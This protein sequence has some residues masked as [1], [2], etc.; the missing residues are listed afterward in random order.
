MKLV[1]RFSACSLLA[2]TLAHDAWAFKPKTHVASANETLDQLA[3]VITFE[4][5]TDGDTLSFAVDGQILTVNV[6]AREAYWAVLNQPE[7]FRAGS[8]GPDGFLDPISGQL[9]AHGNQSELLADIAGELTGEEPEELATHAPLSSRTSLAQFRSIDY[10][11]AMLRFAA[12]D[13][14]FPG[15]DTEREQVLAFVIGYVSHGIGDGFAHTWINEFANGA[16]DVGAGDGIYGPLTEE[17][18]HVAIERFVDEL[19]PNE[20]VNLPG[21]TQRQRLQFQAPKAFLD[22]FYSAPVSSFPLAPD[23]DASPEDFFNFFARVDLVH[24]G[25]VSTFFNAQER[26]ADSVVGWSRLGPFFDLAE[27]YQ[28]G[29]FANTFLDVVD[30]PDQLKHDLAEL[31]PAVDP[32]DLVTGGVVNCYDPIGGDQGPTE[33]EALRKAWRYLGTMNDRLD[34]YRLK[35]Q[36]ARRNWLHL[37]EC[38]LQNITNVDCFEANVANPPAIRDACTVVA[39]L[40]FEDEGNP[41]GLFRGE[42]SEHGSPDVTEYLSDLRDSFRGGSDNSFEANNDHFHIGQNVL[43]MLEYLTD[44]GMVVDE[45]ADVIVPSGTDDDGVNI[46]ERYEDFCAQVR[47]PAYEN[48]LDLELLE[49]AVAGR[50][51]KC[52]AEHGKCV[53]DEVAECLGDAC[54]SEC[55]DWLVLPCDEICGEGG[56]ST[57][58][59]AC[60]AVF[61]PGPFTPCLGVCSGICG[62]FDDERAGCTELAHDVTNCSLE[63]IVCSYENMERAVRQDNYGKQLLTPFKEACD[64]VDDALAYVEQC[65]SSPANLQACVCAN[66]TTAQCQQLQQIQQNAQQILNVLDTV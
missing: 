64:T 14:A 10:A 54:H 51:L 56:A 57:C 22:A 37:S 11:T 55:D 6:S 19:L 25:P 45:F 62:V 2:L 33:I 59:N 63:H 40:P 16:W 18:K 47:D 38:T 66:L 20:L 13:Y 32:F 28:L 3:Q 23:P 30:F 29:D 61:C 12:T 42:L 4:P 8:V 26:L 58:E 41:N 53:K 17:I 5:G 60:E 24:G 39:D 36:A 21:D 49:Y 27:D 7:F 35:A 46:R 50:Q 31:V 65:F 1:G 43:R 9:W 34:V 44:G 52:E 15:G 48:C